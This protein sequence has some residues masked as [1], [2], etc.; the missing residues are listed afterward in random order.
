ML[1]DLFSITGFEMFHRTRD[2][3]A[4]APPPFQDD[5]DAADL[6]AMTDE[7]R[8]EQERSG[9]WKMLVPAVDGR[10]DSYFPPQR[11]A[12]YAHIRQQLYGAKE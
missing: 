7:T 9:S 10:F 11:R 5:Y 6:E 2:A 12:A 3:N 8:W 4:P 1:A